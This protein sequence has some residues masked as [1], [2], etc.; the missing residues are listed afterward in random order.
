MCLICDRVK[1]IQAGENPYYIK[2]FK[3]SYFVL[4]D[5]QYFK[6]YCLLIMKEHFEDLT[7]VDPQIQ[8]EYMTEVFEASK[9]LKDTF[10][11]VRINYSC[12][13]NFVPHIHFHLFPRYEADLKD[14]ATKNP[15]HC[16]D[17]FPKFSLSP[18]QAKAMAGELAAKFP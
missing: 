14:D 1:D 8:N 4:G 12:L 10:K 6:G 15:W 5:H 13:G 2:E 7:D 11:P 9:F 17:D 18:E 3:H 16:I